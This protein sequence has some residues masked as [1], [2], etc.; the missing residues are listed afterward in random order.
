MAHQT[1]VFIVER[2]NNERITKW[3]SRAWEER[4]REIK[5]RRVAVEQEVLLKEGIN[6]KAFAQNYARRWHASRFAV[7]DNHKSCCEN[8]K[9]KFKE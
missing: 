9:K 7:V 4:D 8:T 1:H 5:R 2:R 3:N 6:G